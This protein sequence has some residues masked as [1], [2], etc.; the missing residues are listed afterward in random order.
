MNDGVGLFIFP[1]SKEAKDTNTLE[2]AL[3][4][5]ADG[6]KTV[7]KAETVSYNIMIS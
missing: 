1:A 2:G 5:E 6:C 3:K 7:V 4:M